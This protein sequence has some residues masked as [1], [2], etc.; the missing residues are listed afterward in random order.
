MRWKLELSCFHYD[1]V[2][3]PSRDNITADALTKKEAAGKTKVVL[4][5][6]TS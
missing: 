5:T 1:I 4:W 6:E 2:Y 3:R